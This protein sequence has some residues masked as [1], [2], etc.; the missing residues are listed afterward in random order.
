[1]GTTTE[2]KFQKKE[3]SA[4]SRHLNNLKRLRFSH[5]CTQKKSENKTMVMIALRRVENPEMVVRKT[6]AKRNKLSR[7]MIECKKSPMLKKRE[8]FYPKNKISSS[9]NVSHT[10]SSSKDFRLI[11]RKDSLLSKKRRTKT[12]FCAYCWK[13]CLAVRGVQHPLCSKCRSVGMTSDIAS[14]IFAL[15]RESSS[16]SDVEKGEGRTL[17]FSHDSDDMMNVA[18]DEVA[19]VEEGA[20]DE[21]FDDD[22]LNTSS[23]SVDLTNLVDPCSAKATPEEEFDQNASNFGSFSKASLANLRAEVEAL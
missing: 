4:F 11:S 21:V 14:S 1:M 10:C 16:D 6:V 3:Y 5:L 13:T 20:F 17:S 2:K 9:T 7:R 19:V 15:H 8:I 12:T 18:V 22:S 23:N